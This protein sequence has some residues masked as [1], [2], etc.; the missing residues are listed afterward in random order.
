MPDANSDLNLSVYAKTAL[1]LQEIQSRT[2]GLELMARRLLILMD[3]KRS[4]GELATM[5]AGQDLASLVGQLLDKQC[6]ELVSTKPTPI[7]PKSAPSSQSSD[8]V[9]PPVTVDS[10]LKALPDAQSRSAKEVESARNFMINTV[11]TIY[12]PNTRLSLLES[13]LACKDANDTRAVYF[14]WR[15]SI[16]NSTIGL[17]RLPKFEEDLF[18]VL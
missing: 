15:E 13:I 6:I 1:G 14:Q 2:L 17:K 9:K 4:G 8:A 5:I 12:Q 18:K 3:G 11:N 10:Q 16:G 7:P